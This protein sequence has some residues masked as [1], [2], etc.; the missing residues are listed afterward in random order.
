MRSLLLALVL[1]T[2]PGLGGCKPKSLLTELS[3]AKIKVAGKTETLKVGQ[4]W[5]YWARPGEEQSTFTVCKIES[6]PQ[7]GV[8]VHVGLD[9]LQIKAGKSSTGLLPHLPFAREAIEKSATKL[10]DDSAPL[11][12]FQKGYAEWKQAFDEGKGG[13]FTTAIGETVGVVEEGL[14]APPPPK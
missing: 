14:N 3:D 13:V 8:I 4:R 1:V 11:P 10:V 12:N 6:A 9:N 7:V 2:L 5:S